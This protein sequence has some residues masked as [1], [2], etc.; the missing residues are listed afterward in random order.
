MRV[1]DV[2]GSM[3]HALPAPLERQNLLVV[4]A[5]HEYRDGSRDGR[6]VRLQQAVEILD[7]L[8]GECVVEVAPD[9]VEPDAKVRSAKMLM[10]GQAKENR[11]EWRDVKMSNQ[12]TSTERCRAVPDADGG[13]AQGEDH[14]AREVEPGRGCS[15]RHR[16][17]CNYL[18]RYRKKRGFKCVSMTWRAI[19]AEPYREEP[20]TILAFRLVHPEGRGH[21]L[22][23]AEQRAK[24]HLRSLRH[25]RGHRRCLLLI[26][27][28][29]GARDKVVPGHAAAEDGRAVDSVAASGTV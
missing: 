1:S 26:V 14:D 15:P 12:L 22:E 16:M 11:A 3:R 6:D 24:V 13:G 28:R 29:C 2:A 8:R 19:S 4:V 23:A 10:P 25:G 27:A 5:Q 17:P 18:R 9:E 20:P 21:L 7:L